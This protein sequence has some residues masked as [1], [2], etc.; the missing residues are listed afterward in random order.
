MKRQSSKEF[1]LSKYPEARC[2]TFVIGVTY[3]C[4][5]TGRNTKLGQGKTEINAWVNAK[6]QIQGKVKQP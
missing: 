3:R 2:E 6:K 4:I 5:Y 1:V